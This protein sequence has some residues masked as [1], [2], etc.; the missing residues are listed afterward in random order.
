MMSD[1]SSFN[2][3]IDVLDKGY[4]RLITWMPWNMAEVA[5]N[6]DDGMG[7]VSLLI[8]EAN[9]LA[10]INAAKGSHRRESSEYGPGEARLMGFLGRHGPT[11]P[12]RHGVAQ[13]EIKA[14]MMVARQ[15]FKYRVGSVHSEPS[16]AWD[17]QGDDGSDD[18]LY[19]RNEA[20]RRYVTEEPEFYCPKVWRE[21]PQS[22]K[23]GSGPDSNR[24]MPY[25]LLKEYQSTGLVRYLDMIDQGMAPEMARLFLP[26]Y[27]LYIYWRWTASVQAVAHFLT[28][29]LEDDAQREIQEYAKAVYKLASQ[30]QVYPQAFQ[31]LVTK[32][33]YE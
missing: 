7:A 14:P 15:W 16:E 13:F 12:F 11:S 10:I 2:D 31:E 4:V 29:R 6:N 28:Q 27:G 9:D 17:G 22:K 20:S 26:A 18:P 30:P 3:K 24:T 21:A 19:A 1:P 32:P 25:I 8:D 33:V 23:Q 5:L